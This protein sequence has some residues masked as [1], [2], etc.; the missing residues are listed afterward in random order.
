MLR[1]FQKKR[2]A[3]ER[4]P[5]RLRNTLS[6][7]LE[8]FLPLNGTVKMYNCGPTAY[9][10]VHVGNLRPYVFA[11][12]LRRTLL[13]WGFKVDQVINIT[14]FGHLVSDADEGED[15]MTKGLRREGLAVTMENMRTL[16]ERYAAAF[17]EDIQALGLDTK[18]IRFPRASEFVPQQISLI[19]TLEQKGYAYRTHDGVY[20]DTSRLPDYGKLGGTAA[21]ADTRARIGEN[22]EKRSPHD[23]AL[24]KS[25]ASFGWESPWGMGFPGWHIEC[26]AMIFALLGKQ[27]DI[28]TGGIDHIAIH[29]NNEIA[30]A[31]A[32][33]GKQFVRY[34]MHNEFITIEGRRIGKSEGNAILLSNLAERGISARALRYWF[35]TGHYRTPMNFTWEALEGAST[36]LRRLLQA[37]VSAPEGTP[38]ETFLK[39]FYA[40][41]AEDLDTAGALALVWENIKSLNKATLRAADEVLGLGL[42][43]AKPAMSLTIKTEDLPEGIQ[44]LLQSREAAREHKDFEKADQMRQEIESA[45]Y[46]L[47]DTAE[48]PQITK[49]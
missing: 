33:T 22:K 48:G 8:R 46:E 42:A 39:D 35:L 24:W 2:V 32:I 6:G 25:D 4:A 45:G 43:E 18:H 10:Y 13:A 47:K 41:I 29:H 30:Q 28:H 44:S 34:W 9:D 27:I 26:T 14:D 3:L 49:K 5:L 31:E 20:F 40:R 37:Y 21:A 38:E 12:T 7:E 23:F 16:S 15:K 17:L 19:Q 1:L 36:A 11:D